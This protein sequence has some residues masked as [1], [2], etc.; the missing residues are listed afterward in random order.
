MAKTII[1]I[2]WGRDDYSYTLGT[3]LDIYFI[4]NNIYEIS[5]DNCHLHEISEAKNTPGFLT[6]PP[7]FLFPDNH[8]T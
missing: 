5:T 1:L 7:V 2:R 4:F 6:G 8:F 3:G